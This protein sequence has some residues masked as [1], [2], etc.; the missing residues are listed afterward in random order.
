MPA[1]ATKPRPKRL[2]REQS[3]LAANNTGLVYAMAHKWKGL[4]IDF[5]E[6]VSIGQ[7][8]LCRASRGWDP[9][10]GVKFSGYACQSII[11]SFIRTAQDRQRKKTI[12][13]SGPFDTQRPESVADDNPG[14]VDSPAAR[15]EML[16]K[17]LA[18]LDERERSVLA[19]RI[20]SGMTLQVVGDI[21]G[22]TKERVRQIE[23]AA[24]QKCRDELFAEL[25]AA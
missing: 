6:L 20:Q 24:L 3:A 21:I 14:P 25:E 12:P 19:L 15:A 10:R 13:L 7:E 18:V 2:T 8:A 22:L 4:G 9:T 5:E 11:K 1:V 17:A 23:A 16:E